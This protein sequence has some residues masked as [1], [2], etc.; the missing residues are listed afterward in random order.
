[1]KMILPIFLFLSPNIFLSDSISKQIVTSK[2]PGSSTIFLERIF[3]TLKSILTDKKLIENHERHNSTAKSS[4]V[5][6]RNRY[7]SIFPKS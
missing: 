6:E 7:S 5:S 1:M 2:L 3:S 4:L